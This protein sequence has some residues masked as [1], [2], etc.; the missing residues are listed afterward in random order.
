MAEEGGHMEGELQLDLS[1]YR[2]MVRASMGWRLWVFRG[3]G[4]LVVVL[5]VLALAVGGLG[6]VAVLYLVVGLLL[7]G[8]GELSTRVGWR[9]LRG[10]VDQPWRYRVA[11]EGIG[12]HTPATDVTLGWELVTCAS[13]AP[14]VW[15]LRTRTRQRLAI[16]RAAFSADDA[17]RIDARFAAVQ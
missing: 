7:C 11:E 17:A 16:P 6:V 12:I 14:R 1:I 5:G 13:R 3:L 8:G 9:R 15:T 2:A 10:L 4:A